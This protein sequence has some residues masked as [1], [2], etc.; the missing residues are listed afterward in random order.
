MKVKFTGDWSCVTRA[1]KILETGFYSVKLKDCI[2]AIDILQESL[3]GVGHHDH[4]IVR[5]LFEVK[6]ELEEELENLNETLDS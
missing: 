3:I 2:E 4:D 5:E 6:A 1:I